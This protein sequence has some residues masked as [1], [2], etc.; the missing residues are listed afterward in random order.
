MRVLLLAE[1][2]YTARHLAPVVASRWPDAELRILCVAS[3][4]A[5]YQPGLPRGLSWSGYPLVAPFDPKGFKPRS[6]GD[7]WSCGFSWDPEAG[8]LNKEWSEDVLAAEQWVQ[9]ADQIICMVDQ[10]S[11][12]QSEVLVQKILGKSLAE[13]AQYHPIYSLDERALSQ[14]VFGAP[15][16]EM[17]KAYV[18]H[19][20]VRQYFNH[21]FAVNSVTVLRKTARG[22]SQQP[23]PW[24]SKYQL[25]LV[26][27]IARMPRCGSSQ[28][29]LE[30]DQ[31]KGTGRYQCPEKS[32]LVRG[33]GSVTS[34]S[35][36]LGQLTDHGWISEEKREPVSL[37][38]L[39]QAFVE[40][41]HPGCWDPDLP[42]RIEAW[43]V[44]GLAASQGAIDRYI[45]TFFG[46]QKRYSDA[47]VGQ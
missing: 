13:V 9:W 42:F 16:N 10:G 32:R 6:T 24:V 28:W 5:L 44:K 4:F 20:R 3:P 18:E 47:G 14:A 41:L 33:F 15:E 34:R 36:I 46:K 23:Q 29:I 25:Q 19:G 45:R 37:T 17:A 31:W 30:M 26:Q 8:S 12:F 11:L 7:G 1:K 2:P 35:K 21:Q 38:S 39:G 43:A 27:A 22:V 40:R